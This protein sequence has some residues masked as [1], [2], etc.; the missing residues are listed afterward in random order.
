MESLG[1][2]IQLR[3]GGQ[4]FP[5]ISHDSGIAYGDDLNNKG[6]SRLSVVVEWVL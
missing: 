5:M 6:W 3:K 2:M 1:E 4:H